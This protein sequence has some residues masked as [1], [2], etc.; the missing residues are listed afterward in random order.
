MPRKVKIHLCNPCDSQCSYPIRNPCLFPSPVSCTGPK[1][2]TGAT[3]PTGP[4]GAPGTGT[5]GPIGPTGATGSTGAT[6]ATGP[7]GA[8]I[9]GP[10]GSTGQT[11]ATGATGSTGSTGPTGVTGPSGESITGPIGPTGATGATGATGSTGE[12]GLPGPAN[13]PNTASNIGTL[14][15]GPFAQI[16]GSEFQFNNIASGSP[17]LDVSLDPN[18]NI[19]ITP[20]IGGTDNSLVS[21]NDARLYDSHVINVKSYDPGYG[22][23]SSIAAAVSSITDASPTERYL[24]NVGP[25]IYTEPQIDVPSYVSI[26]GSTVLPTVVLPDAPNHHIFSLQRD[27][28]LSFMSLEGAGLGFA[29]IA[30][31]DAGDSTLCHKISIKNC[32]TGVLVTSVT[33]DCLCYLEYIDINGSYTYGIRVQAFNGF[34]NQVNVDNY[35]VIPTDA[36]PL[37]HTL[38]EG[39][40]AELKVLTS[41]V[42]GFQDNGVAYQVQDGAVLIMLGTYTRD[43]HTSVI[44]FNNSYLSI[45]GSIFDSFDTDIFFPNIGATSDVQITSAGSTNRSIYFLRQEHSS[46]IGEFIG[47][48][49]VNRVFINP[50]SPFNLPGSTFNTLNVG[51]R[52]APYTSVA[53]AVLAVNPVVT[54]TVNGTNVIT[55]S[56]QFNVSMNTFGITGPNIPPNTTFTYVDRNT[57]TLSNPAT[58]AGTN[59]YTIVRATGTNFWNVVVS[60]GIYREPPFTIPSFVTVQGGGRIITNIIA[61]DSTADFITMSTVSSLTDSIVTGPTGTNMAAVVM[62]NVIL[63]EIKG[64]LVTGSSTLVKYTAGNTIGLNTIIGCLFLGNYVNGLLFDGS[65]A[66]GATVKS[67][68]SIQ[69]LQ[70]LSSAPSTSSNVRIFGPFASLVVNGSSFQNFAGASVG[71]NMSDGASVEMSGTRITGAS[72]AIRVENTGDAPFLQVGWTIVNNSSLWDLNIEHPGTFGSVAATMARSKVSV[73]P[74][75]PISIMYQDNEVNG[76]TTTGPFHLGPSND[77]ATDVQPLIYRGATI[78]V[79]SGGSVTDAGGLDVQVT[80]GFG[81]VENGDQLLLVTWIT[82]VLTLPPSSVNYVYVNNLG[83]VTFSVS[84]P[85][86]TEAIVLGRVS[87]LASSIE[88][89]DFTPIDSNNTDNLEERFLRDAIGALYVSGSLPSYVGLQM[90][91]SSGRYYYGSNQYNPS[92]LALGDP[93]IAYFHSG[94]V[95]TTTSQAVLDNTQYDNGTD[96][97]PLSPGFYVK[98]SLY[99]VGDGPREKYMLVYGIGEFSNIGDAN[100]APLA[101]PPA[102]FTEGVVILAS[103]IV[104]QGNPNVVQTHIEQPRLGFNA[105]ALGSTIDHGN[106]LGLLDDDHTQYLLVNGTR[107]MAG[108]LNM[109]TNN[110]VNTGTVNDVTVESHASRHL[111]NGA[112]ALTTGAP[113]I[114]LSATTANLEGV[115][116]SF[117]RSD[118]VHSILTGVASQLQPDQP[119]SVGVSSNLARADHIHNVPTAVPVSVGSTNEQGIVFSFSRSDHVHQGVHSLNVNGGPQR[120]GDLSLQEGQGISIVD[121]GSGQFVVASTVPEGPTGPTG[122]TG[123]IGQTGDTGPTGATGSI[124]PTGATGA[125]GSTGAIGPTGATGSIGPIGAAGATGVTGATGSVGPTGA[126][127]VTGATGATGA[128]GGTGTGGGTLIFWNSGNSNIPSGEYIGYNTTVSNFNQVRIT[129][130]RTGTI[131]GMS[132]GNTAANGAAPT[133]FSAVLSTSPGVVTVQTMSVAV[134]ANAPAGSTFFTVSNPFA[135]SAGASV[136]IQRTSVTGTNMPMSGTLNLQ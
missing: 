75:S 28:E 122:A 78:G 64:C 45:D 49:P 26:S 13:T 50:T 51:T 17:A 67:S 76:L 27:S 123:Q 134:A 113:N 52:N 37:I 21:G 44:A 93:W 115:A 98:H 48:V 132:V 108:N 107:S 68:L 58:G 116:N 70:F 3:G 33:R 56:A 105:T 135:V 118:H 100:G 77:N 19:L 128:T 34:A 30:S 59:Q 72:T 7:S 39:L 1:G 81:Y 24:V 119:N 104:Q 90:S 20:V 18:N 127:G 10:I 74:A 32:D 47:I 11:G 109:G 97:V 4:T 136:A 63:A 103:I 133:V 22:E 14:G 112:D 124:G 130:P 106:L 87:T 9:T 131:I 102:Y 40:G 125:T 60:P 12:T 121:N 73:N 88:F 23:F 57:G 65:V 94:G 8:S 71:F 41:G 25:G 31:L 89:I 66:S 2:A 84:P 110:I 54:A 16:V 29:G 36:T 92:G 129:I 83:I 5:M 114:P 82:T 42:L 111:P 80:G 15:V 126:T 117:A 6:G 96:L 99:I 62:N 55:S 38:V 35:Y 46:N 61:S 86:L 69:G 120:F 101:P 53:Q 95:F 91:V 43:V 79:M 85:T